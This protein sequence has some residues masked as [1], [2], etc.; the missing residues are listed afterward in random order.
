MPL[1]FDAQAFRDLPSTGGT[2][3]IV[4]VGTPRAIAVLIAQSASSSDLVSSVTYGGATLTRIGGFGQDTSTELGAAYGYFKG[5][6]VASSGTVNVVLTAGGTA[7]AWAVTL[8]SSQGVAAEVVTSGTQGENRANPSLTLATSATDSGIAFGVL[9][10][11]QAS[12]ADATIA[13][14]SGYTKLTGSSAGGRAFSAAA[15]CAEY[16]AKSGAN[17]VVDWTVSADDVAFH[18]M[19]VREIPSVPPTV[20]SAIFI[21]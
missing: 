8:T 12:P 13:A 14:G 10:S 20:N 17:V 7:T 2:F 18:A 9:F 3:T 5:S 21:P 16:G 4:P 19:F 6:G 11:G 15:A 1:S